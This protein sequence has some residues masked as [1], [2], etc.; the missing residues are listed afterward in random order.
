MQP[1]H[2]RHHRNCGI[3]GALLAD[4][5]RTVYGLSQA[6]LVPVIDVLQS[7]LSLAGRRGCPAQGRAGGSWVDV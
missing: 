6:G 7:P 5:E 2:R 1:V 3:W 4:Q